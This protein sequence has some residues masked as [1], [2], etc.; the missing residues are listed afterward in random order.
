MAGKRAKKVEQ[1][2]VEIQRRLLGAKLLLGW[3]DEP[4]RFLAVE[5]LSSSSPDVC[6]SRPLLMNLAN[7]DFSPVLEALQY[8]AG[9]L[10]ADNARS[11]CWWGEAARAK[12]S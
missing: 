5:F 1:L 11:R 8:L 2:L 3:V 6:P 4:L 12:Q 9:L 7:R 10:F